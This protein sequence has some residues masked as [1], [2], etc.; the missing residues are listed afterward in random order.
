SPLP[1]PSPYAEQT[2]SLTERHEPE[3][4]P[5]SPVRTVRTSRR[6]PRLRPPPVPGTHIMALRPSSVPLQVPLPSPPAS[7]LADGRDPESDL[8]RATSPTV[9]RVLVIVVTNS[10]FESTAASALVVEL[11]D[12]KYLSAAVPHL[13][14]MLLAPE[15]DPDA[16]DI[17]IPR[18]YAK[19][20]MGPYSSQWQ[21][22]MDAEMASWKSTGTYVDAVPP[23]GANIVDGM[24]IFR[25]KLPSGSP[26]IFKAHYVARGF[27]Q[28]QGADF[29]QTFSPTPKIV[30]M[31]KQE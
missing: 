7:S 30:E 24:W 27:S 3:S 28:R 20:I 17:P 16:P 5:A 14:A 11:E 31:N 1:A 9:P 15:G 21:T 19:A 8:A 22:A 29:L 6:I 10:L 25:V 18:S 4:R 23:T 12:V 26:P 13:M 2:G